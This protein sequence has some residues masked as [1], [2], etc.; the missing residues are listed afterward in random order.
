MG[1]SRLNAKVQTWEAVRRRHLA[2]LSCGGPATFRSGSLR[3]RPSLRQKKP[4]GPPALGKDAECL[5]L[6]ASNRGCLP[7]ATSPHPNQGGTSMNGPQHPSATSFF[8]GAYAAAP[9]LQGREPPAEGNSWRFLGWMVSPG[10]KYRSPVRSTKTMKPW[11]LQQLPGTAEHI[12]TTIP[13]AMAARLQADPAF[14]LASTSAAGRKAAV[15]FAGEALDAAHRLSA[16]TGG[17]GVRVLEL[18]AAPVADGG[19]ASVSALTDSLT[20]ISAWEWR[21]VQIVLDR[22]DAFIPCWPP[23]R[24][25]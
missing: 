19:R 10:W 4:A 23:A 8:E 12:V 9:S 13:W 24:H 18:H 15:E 16:H 14:G 1:R 5:P 2:C 3:G 25:S 22:C 20:E 11:F 6:S 21:S 7:S 17:P